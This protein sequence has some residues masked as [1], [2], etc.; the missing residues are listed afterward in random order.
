MPIDFHS[1]QNRD[2]YSG[3]AVDPEWFAAMRRRIEPTALNVVDIG[4][5]GG[6]YSAAW[7]ELGA[8]SVQGMDFSEHMI[9]AAQERHGGDSRLTFALADAVNTGLSAGSADVVFKRAVVHH[10]AD[11]ESAITEAVRLLR[12]GGVLIV[13]DRT[14]EDV[15]QPAS[16]RHP[17]SYLFEAYPRLL[18][19]ELGRRPDRQL[20]VQ[21]MTAAGLSDMRVDNFWEVRAVHRDR[22]A[23]LDDVAGRTGPG[24]SCTIWTTMNST[25]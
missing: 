24:Q 7:L 23:Y 22:S 4:C 21:Q 14:S 19:V 3:R 17:R 15:E 13:Q 9:A 2:A 10:V 25:T 18:E 8:N 20:L 16:P 5:G 1:P 12:P 6:T 11:T